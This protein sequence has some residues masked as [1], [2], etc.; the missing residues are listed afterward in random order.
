MWAPKKAKV[1]P[2]ETSGG[3]ST[4]NELEGM[5]VRNTD[6][7]RWSVKIK[8]DTARP[9]DGITGN[10]PGHDLSNRTASLVPIVELDAGRR[11]TPVMTS[12]SSRVIDVVSASGDNNFEI[13]GVAIIELLLR[14]TNQRP[15]SNTSTRPT[16]LATAFL[17]SSILDLSDLISVVK[18]ATSLAETLCL[19]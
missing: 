3:C 13:E 11:R 6:T 16:T 4:G 10:H 19:N 17:L 7:H 5:T 2:G 18:L 14:A 15:R 9:K 12:V 1:G 8:I